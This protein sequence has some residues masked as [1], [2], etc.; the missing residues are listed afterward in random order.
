MT[1]ERPTDPASEAPTPANSGA[2]STP[3]GAGEPQAT[4]TGI[5]DDVA[6]KD[7]AGD[8]R[9][10]RLRAWGTALL[11][12]LLAFFSAM[13]VG[14]FVIVLSNE[15]LLG[16]LV[17]DPLTG[18]GESLN[19]VLNAYAALFRGAFGDPVRLFEAL[20][21]LD[22]AALRGSLIPLS[23]TILST[24]PLILTGLAVALAFRA[25]LFNI[26]GEGQLQLGALAAVL[27]GFS[28]EGLPLLV[29]LPL[30]LLAGAAAGAM[31]GF[32]P[33]ALKA[34]TGAH[35]VITTIMLNFVAFRLVDLALRNPLYQRPGRM[36]PISQVVQDSAALPRLIDDVAL[37]AHWG[38]VVALVA[39]VLVSWLLFRSTKG[40]E[41]RAVGLNPQA[42]RYAGMSIGG[43]IVLSMM[44]AGALAGLAGASIVLAPAIRTLTPGLG[45]GAGF[46]GIAIA[47]LGRARPAGV[48]L[49]AFLIGALRA[50]STPMQAATGV[51]IYLVVVIQALVIMFIAAPALVRAIYRIRAERVVGGEA[52]AKG[53]GG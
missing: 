14:A 50:G 51:P 35:E 28:L 32:I 46:D 16:L 26:G 39:A 36:D 25:G 47:L 33:G 5:G 6:R 48:V 41:F 3:A 29:H 53:W 17:S 12:T 21:T 20:L 15:R 30:A 8:R 24:T 52:F 49:A 23:E 1:D 40:F 10:G 34:R 13:V 18:L 9:P 11:P 27:V 44:I 31:W 2:T 37:R 4:T 22:P 43:S 42:A 45:G 7:P 19:T 38:I